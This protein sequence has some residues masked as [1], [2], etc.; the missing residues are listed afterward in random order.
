[1]VGRPRNSLAAIA[2]DGR[3]NRWQDARMRSWLGRSLRGVARRI[4]PRQVDLMGFLDARQEALGG[5][6]PLD[7]AAVIRAHCAGNS[8]FFFVQI[9]AHDGASTDPLAECIRAMR[10]SGLLVEPQE[11]EFR[12]LAEVYADQPQLRFERAAVAH[13][14]GVATLY[15]VKL[16]FWTEHGFPPGIASQISSLNPNQIRRHVELFGGAKLAAREADYLERETVPALTLRSLL[17]R[18]AIERIDLLQIDAEGFDFE[19]VKMIDWRDPPPMIHFETIHLP[20]ADRLAAWRL[21][22]D[23][24]YALF[25]TNSHNTLA[26]GRGSTSGGRAEA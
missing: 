4:E 10:L 16:S 14:D 11:R 9:G 6:A 8:R 19:I 7:L 1:M 26:I 2:S 12:R 5:V 25:A 22:R 21:L 15:K 17:A 20:V 18:H 24:G 23:N 13:E 3:R